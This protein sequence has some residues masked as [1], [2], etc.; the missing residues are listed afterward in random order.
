MTTAFT[1]T[2]QLE[3]RPNPIRLPLPLP[4]LST[5]PLNPPIHPPQLQTKPRSQLLQSR[6]DSLRT[7]RHLLPIRVHY[8]L[9]SVPFI[10]QHISEAPQE[11]EVAL[12][13]ECDDLSALEVGGSGEEGAE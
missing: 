11:D 2:S 13:M 1:H 5:P 9:L 12:I 8:H 7:T 10:A 3:L 6:P 4:I